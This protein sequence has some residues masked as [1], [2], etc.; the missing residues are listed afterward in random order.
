MHL[1]RLIIAVVIV[2][3]VPLLSGC[4]GSG[5]GGAEL[6]GSISIEVI[7]PPA[8]KGIA[9][10]DLPEATNSVRI[11]VLEP[12]LRPEGGEVRLELQPLVPDTVVP[13]G[14]PGEP[15]RVA[16]P[17]VPPGPC[18]VEALGYTS[19]DGT[20]QVIARAEAPAKVLAGQTTHV[21]L[22]ALALTVR[23]EILPPELELGLGFE[24]SD[25]VFQSSAW[26]TA[27]CFDADDNIVLTNVEWSSNYESV[28]RVRDDGLVTAVAP[29]ECIITATEI[30]TG[31]SGVCPVTVVYYIT[32]LSH[33][34]R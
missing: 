15:V 34:I 11:R 14:D 26:L 32:M 29:G 25:R 33:P 2:G 16:I 7:F 13:R 5:T 6:T 18:L 22:V 21:N 27:I 31:T 17:N 28:A 12:L 9:P 4:G 8:P 23:V 1:S 3:M 10:R 19:K 24:S 30:L 20:G